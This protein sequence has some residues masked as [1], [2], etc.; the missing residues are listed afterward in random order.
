LPGNRLKIKSD[1]PL[2]S[3][4]RSTAVIEATAAKRCIGGYTIVSTD[5]VRG[6]PGTLAGPVE[7][8]VQCNKGIASKSSRSTKSSKS[9]NRTKTRTSGNDAVRLAQTRLNELGYSAGYADGIL[10]QGTKAAIEL[11]Q[12]ESGLAVTGRLDQKTQEA[13]NL[14]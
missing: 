11:F 2:N 5:T 4:S 9:A 7:A 1:A 14:P 12:D 6:A 10:G 3:T 8:I 13:L